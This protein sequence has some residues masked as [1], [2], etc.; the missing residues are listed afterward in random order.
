MF[1]KIP[2]LAC[3]IVAVILLTA[4][5]GDQPTEAGEAM[6]ELTGQETMPVLASQVS[7]TI[8][9]GDT[10]SEIA[11][12]FGISLELLTK[13]NNLNSSLIF[14]DDVLVIPQGGVP[15]LLSRGDVSRED[16]M[17]LARVIHAEARGESFTGK[18]AVGAVIL[19]RMDSPHFPNSI[20]EVILQEAN[21]V[22]QFTPV[23]DGTINLTP[24]EAAINAAVQALWG[25]DPTGGALFF[26]N[27]AISTDKWI[28]GLPVKTRIG[29]HL[30]A[31][32]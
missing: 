26:Y 16:L 1:R 23:A 4:G 5:I 17:L 6:A 13:A 14:P 27:P 10:L 7:Y 9:Q 8:Q 29:N 18:V 11:M 20:R 19:N 12:K 21:N 2:R 28:F 30:F 24:D 32:A 3:I 15:A 22:Y 31:G 25:H